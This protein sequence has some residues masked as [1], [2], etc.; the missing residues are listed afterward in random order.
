MFRRYLALAVAVLFTGLLAGCENTDSWVDAQA[1]QGWSAQYGD[2]ANSSYVRSRGPEALRLEWSRSVKGELG[3]QVALS[4]DNRLAVNAQTAGG[5]SLMVWEAD[6]NARQRWC[7]RLVLGGGWSSPLF[8]GFDNVYIGQPG[9]ILSFP[10]TQ[11]I[12]WRQ[13][14]IGM[15][16]TPRLLDDGQLLV[17][18]HLGQVLVFNGHRGTVEGT[19][20]DLVS[21]VDPTDSQ[22]GLG[23][24][25]PARSRCPVAAAPAFSHQTGIVVLSVWQ[26]GAEAPVL[27]GLRYHPGEETLLT[28]EWTSTAVGRGPLASPVLSADGATVYVNGRDQKLWALNSADGTPKWS[29][30]LNYLAQTPPSVSP[31]GL[32]VAGGGPE[33]KL[34]AVRDTGDHGEIAWTRDDVVPLTT[35]SRADGVGYTVAREGGHGQSLVVFDTADGHTL[36]SYPVPEATGWPVGV[37]IGHDHRI[38]TATSDGQVYGFA[39]A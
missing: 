9:T 7:T 6:N 15:P 30:P 32:I 33:A 13:P 1:A 21:G 5:C 37:S 39:P 35:S 38:V 2:A 23:D 16:T 11:W 8:D 29:V 31:D 25:Q 28:Q 17:V 34:T 4:A 26:P 24:C 27:M 10:P 22:R 3:A 12:R 36:N 14:V 18:T 20:M 19:P